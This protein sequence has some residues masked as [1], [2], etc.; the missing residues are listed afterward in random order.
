[1][2][3]SIVFIAATSSIA[4]IATSSFITI[5]LAKFLF[6][7]LDSLFQFLDNGFMLNFF[8]RNLL[9]QI[10]LD[11]L[12][13]FNVFLCLGLSSDHFILGVGFGIYFFQ[14][15]VDVRDSLLNFGN[16]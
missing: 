4:S 15:F 14:I 6:H 7:I 3:I 5:I 9:F 11:L 16:R 1:M 2:I 13:L 10:G 8:I 12:K